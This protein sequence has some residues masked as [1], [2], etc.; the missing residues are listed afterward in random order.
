MIKFVLQYLDL[1][2]TEYKVVWHKLFDSFKSHKWKPTLL[3]MKLLFI[4]PVSNAKVK[5][6]FSLI[7]RI[8]TDARI[9]LLKDRLRSLLR[10]RMEGPSLQDFDPKL[11]M[12]LWCR[13]TPKPK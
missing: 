8:K 7:N 13:T 3:L 9:S 4:L 1:L 5:R 2:K 11:S 12:T 10:V 6:F